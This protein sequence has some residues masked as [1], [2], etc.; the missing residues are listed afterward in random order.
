[1]PKPRKRVRSV[2][3]GDWVSISGKVVMLHGKDELVLRIEGSEVTAL[4]SVCW[5]EE[6]DVTVE[7]IRGGK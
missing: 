7:R 6:P 1:M 2:R 4:R 5:S 3:V